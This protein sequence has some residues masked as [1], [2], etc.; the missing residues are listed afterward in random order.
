MVAGIN[1]LDTMG[2][3]IAQD[4]ITTI[5]QTQTSTGFFVNVTYDM[6]VAVS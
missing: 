1:S 3:I 2:L 6:L 5:T 4:M